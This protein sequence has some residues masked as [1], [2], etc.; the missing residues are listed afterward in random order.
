MADAHYTRGW[1]V[2]SSLTASHSVTYARKTLPILPV[3]HRQ[4]CHNR[5]IESAQTLVAAI[6]KGQP[7]VSP[8]ELWALQLTG[9]VLLQICCRCNNERFQ[10]QLIVVDL[11]VIGGATWVLSTGR[12]DRATL[13]RLMGG[14]YN[15]PLRGRSLER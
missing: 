2:S 11:G 6:C 4:S 7:A 1:C 14:L 15:T 3:R 12:A 13:R 9:E 10:A 5:I 8:A